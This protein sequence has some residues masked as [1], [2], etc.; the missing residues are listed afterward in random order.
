MSL[1]V[2]G[3]KDSQIKTTCNLMIPLHAIRPEGHAD[4]IATIAPSHVRR[5]KKGI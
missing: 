5:D 4:T 1:I 3:L 2:S